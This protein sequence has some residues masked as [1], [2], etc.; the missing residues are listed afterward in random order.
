MPKKTPGEIRLIHHL[1]YPKGSSVNDISAINTSVQYA[2]VDDAVRLIKNAGSHC[3]LAKTDIKNAFRII[4]IQA[5]DH[6]LLGFKWNN[7]Y[8]YG[9]CMP[10][11]CASSCKTFETFSSALEWIARTKLLIDLMLHL[12]DDFLIVAPS[13]DLWHAQLNKFLQLCEFLG[14]PIAPEKTCGPSNVCLLR[15]LSLI[16]C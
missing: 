12:L 2:R 14:V 9:C 10:M 3:F 5:S 6:Y 8:Y 4:P 15:E 1:S 7:Q 16:L 13:Y 11:G